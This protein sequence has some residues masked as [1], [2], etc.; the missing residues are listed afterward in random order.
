MECLLE[1]HRGRRRE[2]LAWRW[3]RPGTPAAALLRTPAT[4]SIV[5]RNRWRSTSSRTS[6][7]R[8]STRARE[9]GVH[10]N[11][12]D[13]WHPDL[14]A[15]GE[16]LRLSD[17]DVVHFQFNFGFFELSRLA[18]LIEHELETRGVVVTLHRTKDATIDGEVVSLSSIKA[19]L[20][21]VD[22][23]IVHQVD[24]AG[25][26]SQTWGSRRMSPWCPSAPRHRPSSHPIEA[27]A[28]S[29]FWNST[30]RWDVRIPLAPQGNARA[31]TSRRQSARR[32]PGHLPAGSLCQVPGCRSPTNT[33]QR[34]G[35]KSIAKGWPTTSF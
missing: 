13:R 27:R 33:R 15:L 18:Q 14:G 6:I 34:C 30:G 11:W 17:A 8:S 20:E 26:S 32:V 7:R 16:A 9:L 35:L 28:A 24:D 2:R 3:S 31:R 5:Q 12:N 21:R 1:P 23:L 10:R 29:G 22:R 4:S 25:T 19:T